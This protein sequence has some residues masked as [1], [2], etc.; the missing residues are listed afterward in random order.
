MGARSAGALAWG[1]QA[2]VAALTWPMPVQAWARIPQDERR[3][4]LARANWQWGTLHP[5][6]ALAGQQ[7]F[8]YLFAADE[9][10]HLTTLLTGALP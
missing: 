2:L 1:L 6:E 9:L 3:Q 7:R 4:S 5:W 8:P 10:A